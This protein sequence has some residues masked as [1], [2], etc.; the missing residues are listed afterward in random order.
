MDLG[1]L[2]VNTFRVSAVVSRCFT[3][4]Q[5]VKFSVSAGR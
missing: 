4:F 2:T 1:V 3:Y 5:V